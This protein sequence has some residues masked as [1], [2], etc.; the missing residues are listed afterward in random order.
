MWNNNKPAIAKAISSKKKKQKD[1]FKIYY[2]VIV[3]KVTQ[4][5]HRIGT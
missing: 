3:I 5:Y 1:N 4:Y 2:T